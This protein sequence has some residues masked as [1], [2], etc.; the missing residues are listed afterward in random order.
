MTKINGPLSLSL[1]HSRRFSVR[2]ATTTGTREREYRRGRRQRR[3]QRLF[4]PFSPVARAR[5]RS[6]HRRHDLRFILL[7]P[8]K[9]DTTYEFYR[10]RGGERERSQKSIPRKTSSRSNCYLS[11]AASASPISLSLPLSLSSF[12]GFAFVGSFFISYFYDGRV[13][14]IIIYDGSRAIKNDGFCTRN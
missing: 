8:P 2:V 7:R 5:A 6:M 11:W 12:L 14:L 3:W 13:G 9:T 4:S 10:K 1:S